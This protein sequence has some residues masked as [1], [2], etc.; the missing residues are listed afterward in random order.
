MRL[1]VLAAGSHLLRRLLARDTL[2][3]RLALLPPRSGA[4]EGENCSSALPQLAPTVAAQKDA[5]DAP[6][7]EVLEALLVAV[8][9]AGTKSSRRPVRCVESV[10]GAAS[11]STRR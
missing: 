9:S 5:E 2:L 11:E 8:P 3:A 7:Q 6:V 4:A 10:G 1:A